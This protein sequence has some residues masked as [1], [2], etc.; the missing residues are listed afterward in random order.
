MEIFSF[1]KSLD[2]PL[3]QESESFLFPQK[4]IRIVPMHID[5]GIFFD[6][7]EDVGEKVRTIYLWEDL[8]I[9]KNVL[10]KTWLAGEIC[11]RRPVFARNCRL[12]AI[13]KEEADLFFEESH[14]LG[15]A[16]AKY[17]YGL[18]C[19]GQ[20]AAAAAF[21]NMR[22]MRRGERLCRS[23]EWVR[24]ASLPETRMVGGM[25]KLLSAFVMEHQ[26]DDVMS[27]ANKDWSEGAAYIKLG[28]EAAGETPPQAYWLDPQT[29]QRYPLKRHPIPQLHW[30]RVHGLGSLKFM[31]KYENN[32][33]IFVE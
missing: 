3:V 33:T 10:V 9:R 32:S 20:L 15:A 14:L 1:L 12:Q 21:S 28:F 18:Y 6:V 7:K 16:R 17:Y 4:R 23:A 24:Y 8:W 22:M 31:K 27:Y 5:R 19:R 26:P 2:S 29:M 11:G 13:K 25:G 30:K